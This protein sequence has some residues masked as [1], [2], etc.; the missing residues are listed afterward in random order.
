MVMMRMMMDEM[1]LYLERQMHAV[2]MMPSVVEMILNRTRPTIIP[3][4]VFSSAQHTHIPALSSLMSFTA[5][6]LLI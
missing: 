2:I 5:Q 1:C 3:I 4:T 6:R